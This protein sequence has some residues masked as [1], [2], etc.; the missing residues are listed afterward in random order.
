[1]DKIERIAFY[2]TSDGETFSTLAEAEEHQTIIE[3]EQWFDEHPDK[4][5]NKASILVEFMLDNKQQFKQLLD[6]FI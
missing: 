4:P 5:F 2:K 1:M 3:F 6:K